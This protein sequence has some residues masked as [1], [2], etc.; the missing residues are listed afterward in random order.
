MA[1]KGPS[2]WIRVVVPDWHGCF[3]DERAERAFLQDLKILDPLQI[4]YLGDGVDVSGLFNAHPNNYVA[5]M[6]YSYEEDHGRSNLF[7][8]RVQ[9]AARRAVEQYYTEGN[10]EQHVERW[11][12]RTLRN[13]RDAKAHCEVM[14]P[15]K[16]LR[17]K[18]RGIKY[19]R[20]S[21]FHHGLSVRGT[22]KLGKCYFTHGFVANKYA[23]A[24]HL[25]SFGACVVHGH[26]HRAQEFRTS[27]VASDTIGAWSPGTLAQLQPLYRHTAPSDWSH[28]YGLQCV[29][30]SGTFLHIN[31]PIIRG[32]SM[33]Q[34]LVGVGLVKRRRAA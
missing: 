15:E 22:I 34:S 32:V 17:L 28:G 9:D 11:I 33:L 23:T 4:V 30:R 13:E 6:A 18:E 26:T 16:K 1:S 27:T 20:M 3:I 5:D 31:V 10:H 8:D 12:A 25:H 19:F 14:S 29:Q 7:L 21:E 2:S 24:S